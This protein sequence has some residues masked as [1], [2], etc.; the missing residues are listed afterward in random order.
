MKK[1]IIA[2][3]LLLVITFGGLGL[4]GCTT[5]NNNE[6]N[7]TIYTTFYPIYDFTK[8]IVGNTAT[9]VKL[10]SS[11]ENAHSYELTPKQLAAMEDEADVIITNGLNMEHYMENLSQNIQDKIFEASEGISTLQIVT[12]LGTTKTDPHLWTSIKNAKQMMEN[13]KNHLV[14]VNAEDGM[15]Y[16]ANYA[17]YAVL[18]DGLDAYY[19]SVISNFSNTT[20]IVSHPAFGYLAN[21]YGLTQVG[22]SGL[23]TD[24]EADAQTVANIISQINEENISVVFYQEEL[25]ATIATA[26]AQETNATTER[27]YTVASLSQTEI[28]AG[29][30]YLS[31]M[32]KNLLALVNALS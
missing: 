25:N 30:D 10:V 20:F 12:S 11:G 32:A 19:E 28:D 5:R 26:I 22:I 8:K 14:A 3:M 7:F 24:D 6:E 29:E 16:E 21:D 17:K 27:L 9:V 23:E 13:I 15:I 31:M 4:T 2:I 18:L 1:N